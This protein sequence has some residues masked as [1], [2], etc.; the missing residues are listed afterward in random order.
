MIDAVRIAIIAI[1]ISLLTLVLLPVQLL[2]LRFDWPVRRRIPRFW[3]RAACW[4][5]GTRIHV[6]GVLEHRRPLMLAANHSSWLDILVLGAVADVVY[7]AKSEVRDWPVF[8]HLARLQASV[9]VERERRGKT[10]EQANEIAERM[11]AGEV[12]VLFP[13]GTTSDGNRMLPVK[14]SLFG[15]AS[16]AVPHVPEKRVYIQPVAIA[17][18]KLHG[19]ALGHYHRPLAAWPGDVELMPHLAGLLRAGALDVEITFCPAI[20]FDEDS[21]R[22]TVSNRVGTEIDQAF[23]ASLRHPL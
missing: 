15:A 1:L 11:K 2:A 13:E 7:V 23:L 5:M 21:N 17:Y 22:K 14:S 16:S 12:M 6:K 18:T 20:T 4:L 9:F 19:I 10:G 3:H 8:G